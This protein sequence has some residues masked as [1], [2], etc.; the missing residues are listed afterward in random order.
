M[1]IYFTFFVN[2]GYLFFSF[3]VLT[4]PKSHVQNIYGVTAIVGDASLEEEHKTSF[5]GTDCNNSLT[6]KLLSTV[7]NCYYTV[8]VY[9]N[10]C[11]LFIS[12]RDIGNEGSR[13]AA[14]KETQSFKLFFISAVDLRSDGLNLKPCLFRND[15]SC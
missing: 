14:V 10:C 15:L 11:Q 7:T 1:V 12:E 4:L 3:S 2:N 6:C 5:A 8:L 13:F 9:F